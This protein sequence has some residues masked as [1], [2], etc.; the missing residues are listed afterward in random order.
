MSSR[1]N[2]DN[3]VY[4]IKMSQN[5]LRITHARFSKIS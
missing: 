3:P 4:P 2:A 5:E 1:T